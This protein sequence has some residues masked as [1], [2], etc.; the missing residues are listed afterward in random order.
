MNNHDNL[1]IL[2]G[3]GMLGSDL[4][5][6]LAQAG[7]NVTVRDLPECDITNTEHLHSALRDAHTVINC[8]AFTNV[9]LAEEQARKA[10]A[11]NATAV[12]AVG[13][14]AGERGI[15]VVHISTD[16]VFDG[17]GATPWRETDAPNPL[18]VYGQTKLEGERLLQQSGAEHLIIRV[19]WSYGRHGAN[20]ISRL[21]DK[22]R[23]GGELKIVED[24]IGAP[25]WTSDMSRAIAALL[26]SRC[27]GLY[28]FANTGYTSRYAMA[29]FLK[30]RL[31]L[32]N[33][34][35][36]CLTGEFPVRAERPLNS[37]FDLARIQA[38]LTYSI[39]PWQEALEDY[40]ASDPPTG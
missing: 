24:Q 27:R 35:V 11:V 22:A 18:N 10:H 6:R 3:R 20:F 16:F 19:E 39:R 7:H 9:D 29:L 32:P 12:G 36:P 33:R 25:T 30:Q 31:G 38:E 37:R 15:R 23:S 21:L 5:A 13:T 34:I 17:R 8:A 14:I 4:A 28:H 2:G 40:L 1:V 26:Q